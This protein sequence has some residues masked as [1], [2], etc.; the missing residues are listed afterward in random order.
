MTDILAKVAAALAD[1][2]HRK[3]RPSATEVAA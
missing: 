3:L 2:H 1:L